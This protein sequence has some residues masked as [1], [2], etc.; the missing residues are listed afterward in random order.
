MSGLFKRLSSRRS[1][2]PEGTEPPAAAEPGTT[3]AP[4]NTPAEPEGH[5][6]LFS[7]PA[8]QTRV[9]HDSSEP[10]GTASDDL[11]ADPHTLYGRPALDPASVEPEVADSHTLYGRPA[12]DPASV[13]PEVADSHT[14]YGRPALDPASVEPEVADSHTLY[15]A[16][17]YGP[18]PAGA[19]P[20]DPNAPAPFAYA[21][22]VYVPPPSEP[23]ADLP[24][25][26]DPDE[27]G[28]P[29]GTSA[30]RGKLRRRAAFLRAARELLLRDLGGFVYELHRTAHD[31]EHE[32]HRRLRETKLARLG[33]VD[34]ELHEIEMRLDDVRRQVLVREPGVGGECPHCGELFGSAAHYC[35]HCGNPLTEA[36]RRELAKGQV[37]AEPV[38]VAEPA[39]EV[40]ANADQPTQEIPAPDAAFQWPSRESAS[41]EAA[42]MTAAAAAP[43]AAAET[44][45]AAVDESGAETNVAGDD[46]AA[47]DPTPVGVGAA[48]GGETPGGEGDA[49]PTS[50]RESA[51]EA[52]A[53]ARR[54]DDGD[55]ADGE[56]PAGEGDTTATG[57][58]DGAAEAAADPRLVGDGDPADGETPAR[59]GDTTATGTT[60][61]AAETAADARLAG[62]GDPAD[63][64]TPVGDAADA[65]PSGDGEAADSSSAA[66][67]YAP[68]PVRS[69]D[70]LATHANG[71]GPGEEGAAAQGEPTPLPADAGA[72]PTDGTPDVKDDASDAPT[73]DY[74]TWRGQAANGHDDSILRPVERRP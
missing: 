16:E 72:T 29:V 21:A 70:P 24:A 71:V 1:G 41:A 8:A 17:A 60:D 74:D 13:E 7:D 4:A 48:T 63:D 12:L 58:T 30:R 28:A 45:G 39:P 54:A 34:A 62:D 25:G 43:S 42:A 32:A 44:V 15:G 36:A 73:R 66:G 26:L 3:D 37:V 69:G 57:A 5:R 68:A 31:I 40:V 27:L 49:T 35:S 52:A 18:A 46:E 67:E 14:L 56:T 64:V 20:Y 65:Q 6:P 51:A 53:D 61:G 9:L 23:V 19:Q 2:G 33:R 47:G 50:E 11:P 10:A 22:P 59:E 55:P 38:V